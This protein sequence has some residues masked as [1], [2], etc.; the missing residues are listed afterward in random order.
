[1]HS[2]YFIGYLIFFLI[3]TTALIFIN[4]GQAVTI[5]NGQRTYILDVAM[6]WVT[7]LGDGY[8][9]AAVVLIFLIYRWRFGL[10]LGLSGI[11]QAAVSAFLKRIVF[12]RIARP[13]KYFEDQGIALDLV[14]NVD[15][16][17]VFSFPSGHTMTIFML[18]ALL[19]FTL[20]PKR[21]HYLL[22]FVAILGGFSRI[23]LLQHFLQDV[24]VGSFVGVMLAV[25]MT[26]IVYPRLVLKQR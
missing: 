11:L 7:H 23:Y 5:I 20:F 19:C 8:F 21:W 14:P 1:M 10:F 16:A 9:F 17:R 13:T 25:L 3:G 15:F 24:I 12:G 4:Y 18:T 2:R 26:A 6:P 22:L